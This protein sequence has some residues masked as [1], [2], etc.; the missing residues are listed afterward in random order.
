MN[1]IIK[2]KYSIRYIKKLSYIIS[3]I[4]ALFRKKKFKRK[5]FILN[6]YRF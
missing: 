5:L 2:N 4:K 6:Y 3:K 1:F